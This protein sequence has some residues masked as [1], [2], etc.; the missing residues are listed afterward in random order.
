MT[1]V[2]VAWL[3][4][5]AGLVNSG[6]HCPLVK[7]MTYQHIVIGHGQISLKL[8]VKPHSVHACLLM[9]ACAVFTTTIQ[10]GDES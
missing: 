9:T 5:T 6:I 1:T 2:S 4:V 3:A 8:N 7:Y 10:D